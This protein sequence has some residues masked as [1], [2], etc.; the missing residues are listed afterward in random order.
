MKEKPGVY[1]S[2][3]CP[4]KA[5]STCLELLSIGKQLLIAAF[6]LL[7]N[8]PSDCSSVAFHFSVL[9]FSI[10][11][12][13]SEI[14]KDEAGNSFWSACTVAIAVFLKCKHL[15]KFCISCW[16][17]LV[18]SFAAKIGKAKGHLAVLHCF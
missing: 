18:I 16:N 9:M 17:S 4:P 15:A 14:A 7:N 10:M 13:R 6:N 1:N 12:W 2:G 11:S 8:V 5:S 3:N